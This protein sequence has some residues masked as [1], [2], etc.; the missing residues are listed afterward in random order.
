MPIKSLSELLVTANDEC[1]AALRSVYSFFSSDQADTDAVSKIM[2]NFNTVCEEL[3]ALY[4]LTEPTINISLGGLLFD[5]ALREKIISRTNITK[6]EV[7]T[8]L[9]IRYEKLQIIL[10]IITSCAERN[11]NYSEHAAIRC[12]LVLNLH[13]AELVSPDLE[14]NALRIFERVQ[15]APESKDSAMY[16]KT[17][18]FLNY[19][20]ERPGVNQYWRSVL[21]EVI[22]PSLQT[23]LSKYDRNKIDIQVVTI[24][25]NK[26][27]LCFLYCIWLLERI[28]HAYKKI[29]DK[30]ELKVLNNESIQR[31]FNIL[32]VCLHDPDLPGNESKRLERVL[33]L[34]SDLRLDLRIGFNADYKQ[35]LTESIRCLKINPAALPIFTEIKR[36]LVHR[37]FL[38]LQCMWQEKVISLEEAKLIIKTLLV[39]A[40]QDLYDQGFDLKSLVG[41]TKYLPVA[42][43]ALL[44]ALDFRLNQLRPNEQDLTEPTDHPAIIPL[45]PNKLRL[46]A[47]RN[48]PIAVSPQQHEI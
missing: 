14:G 17:I 39:V 11:S 33:N 20:A 1:E 16:R 37:V 6:P 8:A 32:N 48:P 28:L 34:V 10:R 46:I 19:V 31:A 5:K 45:D 35:H 13:E 21:K 26:T 7:R 15:S 12:L 25:N 4:K 27:T 42:Q 43:K 36:F 2:G 24:F 3:F 22:K 40:L 30:D 44:F 38:E 29:P 18:S 47:E 9:E 41:S 23:L